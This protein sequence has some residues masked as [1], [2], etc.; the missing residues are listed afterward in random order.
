[1]K[2]IE[3]FLITIISLIII[4]C[5][6]DFTDKNDNSSYKL[7]NPFTGDFFVKKSKKGTTK[8]GFKF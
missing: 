2:K 1:M 8:T 3:I 4:S 5:K 7:N 6:N